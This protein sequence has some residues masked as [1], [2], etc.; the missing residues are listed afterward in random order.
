MTRRERANVREDLTL[1]ACAAFVA[2]FFFAA[3]CFYYA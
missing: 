1:T 2:G 3:F